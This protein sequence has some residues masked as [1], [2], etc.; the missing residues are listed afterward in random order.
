MASSSPWALSLAWFSKRSRCTKG[1]LSSVY[2]L[3]SS[4]YSQ[5]HTVSV[6]CCTRVAQLLVQ[7]RAHR[8]STVATRQ[9]LVATPPIVATLRQ[10]GKIRPALLVPP[11]LTVLILA[12]RLRV[13]A[14]RADLAADKELEA[15]SEPWLRPV[16]LGQRR[17]DLLRNA[18]H[19]S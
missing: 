8:V 10:T 16:V 12:R 15:L 14:W 1:S 17:H 19:P 3:H 11:S 18:I 4:W 9:K 5:V 6:L 2:A 13:G 7:P